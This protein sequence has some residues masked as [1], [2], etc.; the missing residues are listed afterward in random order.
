MEP[1][2]ATLVGVQRSWTKRLLPD[3]H[4]KTGARA[5]DISDNGTVVGE[6]MTLPYGTD[7]R[8]VY[9]TPA[10]TI[11][12][13][14]M[15]PGTT[16]GFATA[17]SD[18]GAFVVGYTKNSFI[19][20]AVRWTLTLRNPQPDELPRCRLSGDP[21]ATAV[22]DAG[23]VV[24]AIGQTAV[25]W[26]TISSCPTPIVIAGKTMTHARGINDA[27]QYVGLGHWNPWSPRGFVTG[28]IPNGALPPLPGEAWTD[29][30]AVND[31]G[32]IAGKSW[33]PSAATQ[34]AVYWSSSGPVA[35]GSI[36]PAARV[37]VSDNGRFVWGLP[38]AT[39]ITRKGNVTNYL[40]AIPLGVNRC[41]DIVGVEAGQAVRY[42]KNICD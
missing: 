2:S 10:G 8:P 27:N 37:A 1:A 33:T 41:G 36:S 30:H 31:L 22:N 20:R 18:K 5:N 4:T 7:E 25:S 28:P 14:A 34:T 12:P 6:S 35:L 15:P 39:G 9:W 19:Q 26:A 29:A 16:V 40:S 11:Q 32:V 38:N 23:I 3:F 42:K 13:L 17:I 24:G 21:I